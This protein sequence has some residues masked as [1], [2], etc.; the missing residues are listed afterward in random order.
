MPLHLAD[1]VVMDLAVLGR[2]GARDPVDVPVEE[3]LEA[4]EAAARFSGGH[5]GPGRQRQLR[6]GDGGIEFGGGGKRQDRR[7]LAGPG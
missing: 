7:L 6:G 5:A 1:G 4:E 3:I 2:N